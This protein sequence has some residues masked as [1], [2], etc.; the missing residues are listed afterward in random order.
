MTGGSGDIKPQIL[1]FTNVES[2]VDDYTVSSTAV[3][4][5]R[6]GGQRKKSAVIEV[7]KAIFYLG[8]VNSSDTATAHFGLIATSDLGRA[9]G[10]TSTVATWTED[11]AEPQ[12]IASAG[13][14]RNLSTNGA[15][16]EGW[17]ITVDLTDNNGNGVL[18]ATDKIFFVT[19]SDGNAN[20][21][22]HV[23]KLVYRYVYVGIEEYVGIVQ[24][25]L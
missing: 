22:R 8:V 11:L 2:A 10:D 25:Q 4:V 7:L 17:P 3:P 12:V 6:L 16:S 1:S 19:G 5:F 9:T 23:C 18:V 14:S 20:T 24:S 21:D 13:T 15:T